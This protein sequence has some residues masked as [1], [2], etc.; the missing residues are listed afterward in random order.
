MAE[1][2]PGRLT[3]KAE[4]AIVALLEHPT[5]AEAAKACGLSERSMWRWLQR[6]DF[7]AR[8]KQAQR[9]V[10]DTSITEL[11]NATKEA[12]RTLR[13]NLTCGNAFAENTAAQTIL[14]QSLKAIEMQ[15]LQER[16]TRLEQML[17]EQEKG[18]GKRW[19]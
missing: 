15:E 2:D 12:V 11:Q 10:V 4:Q 13:R 8:Y 18:K 3:R 19:G 14:A 1:K 9:V 17:A 6:E 5:I 7:Q 16:I